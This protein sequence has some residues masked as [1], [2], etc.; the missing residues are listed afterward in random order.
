MDKYDV[1]E[2]LITAIKLIGLKTKENLTFPEIFDLAHQVMQN[3]HFQAYLHIKESNIEETYTLSRSELEKILAYG[4]I[5]IYYDNGKTVC[6]VLE[7]D[8]VKTMS[9]ENGGVLIWYEGDE[10]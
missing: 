7:E 2:V 4:D 5:E 9:L 10:E 8:E 3:E 6:F 1:E